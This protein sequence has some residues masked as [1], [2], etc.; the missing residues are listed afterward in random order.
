[1]LSLCRIQAFQK[2]EYL[3]QGTRDI[4]IWTNETNT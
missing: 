2:T 1:V 4:H 3:Q